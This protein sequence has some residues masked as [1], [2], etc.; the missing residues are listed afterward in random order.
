MVNILQSFLDFDSFL[1]IDSILGEAWMIL[2]VYFWLDTTTLL[3][4]LFGKKV[5]TIIGL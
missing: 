4:I 1:R 2:I 5:V 3:G